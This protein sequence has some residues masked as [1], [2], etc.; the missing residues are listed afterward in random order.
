MYSNDDCLA[1]NMNY[2][3]LMDR[4]PIH[5]SFV[6]FKSAVLVSHRIQFRMPNVPSSL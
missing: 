2:V 4:D 1:Q 5:P 3:C 6:G